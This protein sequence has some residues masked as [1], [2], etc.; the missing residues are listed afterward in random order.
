MTTSTS[1]DATATDGWMRRFA[2]S[3]HATETRLTSLDQQVGDGDFGTNLTAG[4]DA[5]LRRLDQ[6]PG[7]DTDPA[8]PLEAA[9]TAFLDEVGGTSGPLFGLLLQ[10]LAAAVVPFALETGMITAA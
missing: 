2:E 10:S 7:G 8:A 6:L 1:H 3:A 9:A 4:A 5:A